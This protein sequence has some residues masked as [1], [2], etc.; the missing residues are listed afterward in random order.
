MN[1]GLLV[2]ISARDEFAFLLRNSHTNSN[3][4]TYLLKQ[5]LMKIKKMY[6]I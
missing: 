3:F 4:L 5:Q 1:Y 2:L 6:K